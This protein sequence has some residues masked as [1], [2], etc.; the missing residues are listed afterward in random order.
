MCIRDR[1]W[2]VNGSVFPDGLH[3]YVN[4]EQHDAA[5]TATGNF[6]SRTI[7]Q[8][9]L[10]KTC[11]GDCAGAAGQAADEEADDRRRRSRRAGQ[12]PGQLRSAGRAGA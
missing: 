2:A 11:A 10:R 12:Q 3:N 7:A 6:V 4:M 5:L 8:L 1:P 9:W